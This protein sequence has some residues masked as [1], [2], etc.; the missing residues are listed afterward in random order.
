LQKALEATA[1]V[2]A[3]AIDVPQV[4]AETTEIVQA[5]AAEQVAAV[6]EA[7]PGEEAGAD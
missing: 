6:K 5:G 4:V 7:M 3:E 2:I 1:P